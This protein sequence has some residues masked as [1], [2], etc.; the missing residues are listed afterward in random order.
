MQSVLPRRDVSF[1]W[2]PVDCNALRPTDLTGIASDEPPV[3]IHAPQHRMTKGTDYLLAAADSLKARGISMELRLIEKTPRHEA[4]RL[5]AEAEIIADQFCMSA[6][7]MF[8]LEGLALGKTVLTYLDRSGSWSSCCRRRSC[9]RELARPGAR[10]AERYQSIEALAEVWA[11]L[12]RHVWWGEP[13][14]IEQTRHFSPER[15]PRS[16]TEDPAHGASGRSRWTTCCRKFMP[17]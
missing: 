1:K 14:G 16:F 5:Y 9:G 7:G 10:P 12:Y 4:L 15:N 11:Q 2:F 6:Y 3:V 8:A 17:H 13:L